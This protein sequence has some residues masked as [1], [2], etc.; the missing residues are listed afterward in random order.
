[1]KKIILS[2]E[3]EKIRRDYKIRDKVLK[4]IRDTK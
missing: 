4:L 2:V 1:M 3:G